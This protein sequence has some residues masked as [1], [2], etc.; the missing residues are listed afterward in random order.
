MAM[1][2][3]TIRQMSPV[4]RKLAKLINEL[5]STARRLRHLL[6]EIQELEYAV[7]VQTLY[8]KEGSHV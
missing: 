1:R 2:K 5:Q 6:L 7:R 3:R 4:A 8:G